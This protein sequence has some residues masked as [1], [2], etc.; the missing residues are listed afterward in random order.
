M[1]FDK[2]IQ[3]FGKEGYVLGLKGYELVSVDKNRSEEALRYLNQS[4]DANSS[5]NSFWNW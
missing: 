4:L 2:R 1:I 3:Y 5:S